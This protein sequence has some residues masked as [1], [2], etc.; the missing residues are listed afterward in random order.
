MKCDDKRDVCANIRPRKKGLSLKRHFPFRQQRKGKDVAYDKRKKAFFF[1]A[2]LALCIAT[3]RQRTEGREKKGRL[4][5]LRSVGRSVDVCLCL[6]PFRYFWRLVPWF[7]VSYLFTQK[8]SRFRRR[9]K[10][11]R[12]RSGIFMWLK[13][14]LSRSRQSTDVCLSVIR[15][16]RPNF[17]S[18]HAKCH[19]YDMYDLLTYL[20][21]KDVIVLTNVNWIGQ[22]SFVDSNIVIH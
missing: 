13:S 9:P 5:R 19:I 17:F 18:A 6:T 4:T 15:T 2:W 16:L 12:R 20:R 22:K 14:F 11:Y 7:F 21:W 1:I 3:R 8:A 10:M